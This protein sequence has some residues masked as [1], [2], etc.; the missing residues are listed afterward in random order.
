MRPSGSVSGSYGFETSEREG[1]RFESDAFLMCMVGSELSEDSR[2]ERE[3]SELQDKKKCL[4]MIHLGKT[5]WNLHPLN[6]I[7][8]PSPWGIKPH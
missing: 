6:L 3:V 8:A 1:K 2:S 5:H 4:K 7:K